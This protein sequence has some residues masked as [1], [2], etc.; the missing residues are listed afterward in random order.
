MRE[1]TEQKLSPWIC[2]LHFLGSEDFMVGISLA[3][4][5]RGIL[6]SPVKGERVRPKGEREIY[7][8]LCLN[9]INLWVNSWLQSSQLKTELLCMFPLS[10]PPEMTRNTVSIYSE[11]RSCHLVC[12]PVPAGIRKG[13]IS[14]L[15]RLLCFH[16]AEQPPMEGM[17]LWDTGLGREGQGSAHRHLFHS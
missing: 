2:C 9:K 17:C 7:Y 16:M 1:G 3:P 8:L 10:L 14:D 15:D 11:K 4:A 12:R 6:P 5:L 13:E